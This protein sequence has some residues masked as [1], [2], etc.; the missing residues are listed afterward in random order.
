M[1]NAPS[2]FTPIM[3]HKNLAD[4]ISQNSAMDVDLP[5]ERRASFSAGQTIVEPK[6]GSLVPKPTTNLID[7][8]SNAATDFVG[9]ME[10]SIAMLKSVLSLPSLAPPSSIAE[11]S[12]KSI[13]NN[14][15]TKSVDN[16]S[17][18][19]KGQAVIDVAESS[20]NNAKNGNSVSLSNL[21][22]TLASIC[23]T[24]E[25]SNSNNFELKTGGGNSLLSGLLNS[26]N[27]PSFITD[28][29][30]AGKTSLT[31]WKT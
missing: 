19:V 25:N 11:E 27:V 23:S 12:S 28:Q 6:L 9:N 3:H 14:S 24:S 7:T 4:V 8:G 5:P 26:F 17:I 21:A 10:S 29:D 15:S 13:K 22:N 18:K 31:V 20:S 1:N 16:G 2:A 30:N